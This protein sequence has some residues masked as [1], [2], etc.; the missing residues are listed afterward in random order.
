MSLFLGIDQSFTS[1]G[2]C[3]LDENG[4]IVHH[5]TVS[6][7][8]VDHG[9]IFNRAIVVVEKIEE[10]VV[11]YHPR[12]IALEGLAFSKFGNATRDLA[13]LQMVIVASLRRRNPIWKDNLVI[14]SPNLLKKYATG[15][16]S[17]DKDKMYEALSDDVKAVFGGYK[18]TKGR[19]DVVDAYWLSRYILDI[20]KNHNEDNGFI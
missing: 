2:I 10:L 16:G 5:Q 20:Y 4:V 7:T 1:T 8:D 18:K 13:G 9:D 19:S 14:V 15:S 3:V 17:A 12:M 11:Q 6:T